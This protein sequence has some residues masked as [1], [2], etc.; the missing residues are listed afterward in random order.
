MEKEKYSTPR[1]TI[2]SI[3]FNNNETIEFNDD[4]IV[5]LVGGNNVGKSTTLREILNYTIQNNSERNILV[6]DIQYKTKN[7]QKPSLLKYFESTF[8]KVNNEYFECL[9]NNNLYTASINNI[10]REEYKESEYYKFFVS[11]LSTEDRL[12]ITKPL[13]LINMF[14]ERYNYNLLKNLRNKE[15]IQRL[16]KV[17]ASAFDKG[18]LINY[19]EENGQMVGFYKI[20]DTDLIDRIMGLDMFTAEDEKQL[21]NKL[22]NQGDGIRSTVGMLASLI[23]NDSSISLIDEPE[24]F[25]HPPQARILGKNLVELSEGKQCFIATHNIDFIKGILNTGSSRVKIIKISRNETSNDF[26]I[27]DN[28]TII[29]IGNDKNLKYTNILDGLFYKEC[30]ICENESDCKFYSAILENVNEKQYQDSLFCAFG[31]KNQ[32]KSII[33]LLNKIRIKWRIISDIDV[34]NDSNYLE[35]LLDSIEPNKY[36]KIKDE[37]I[38]FIEIYKEQNHE[39]IRTKEQIKTD[40]I[41]I[42]SKN[43]D[44]YITDE[45][46]DKIENAIKLISI[47]K[48]LKQTGTSSVPSGQCMNDFNAIYDFLK[49]NHIYILKC[50]EIEGLVREVDGHGSTWVEK[51]FNTYSDMNNPIYNNAKEF[52]KE[53]F[54]NE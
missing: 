43:T 23:V 5:L 13:F 14:S 6:K 8:K 30:I 4:D 1:V 50:G 24:V 3:K 33:P 37:H 41:N 28:N 48:L 35:K 25:L 10:K 2:K 38:R 44:N 15:K 20:G 18:I 19:E 45:Q 42:L 16:N 7:Y 11:F 46:H 21:L 54:E 9:L 31:G 40:I 49:L 47:N 26:D 12:N 22:C 29:E 17:L 32:F 39:Q 27:I 52:I 34:V 51:V 53:V 36:D